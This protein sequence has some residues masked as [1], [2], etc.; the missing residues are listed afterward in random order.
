MVAPSR[1]VGRVLTRVSLDRLAVVA[2]IVIVFLVDFV[3][4]VVVVV[5]S[6]VEAV[7]ARPR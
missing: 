7:R 6:F 4:V 3:V 1:Y 5:V 2:S